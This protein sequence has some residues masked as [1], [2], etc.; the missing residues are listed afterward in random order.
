MIYSESNFLELDSTFPSVPCER[1]KLQPSFALHKVEK[2]SDAFYANRSAGP[3]PDKARRKAA[4]GL[5][6]LAIRR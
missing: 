2:A 6:L 1:T 4:I 3:N 5:R